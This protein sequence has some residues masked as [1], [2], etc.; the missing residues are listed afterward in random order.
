MLEETKNNEV[1]LTRVRTSITIR[2]DVLDKVRL[3]ATNQGISASR[4]IE[5]VLSAQFEDAESSDAEV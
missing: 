3:F 2:P 1:E 5:N 4:F